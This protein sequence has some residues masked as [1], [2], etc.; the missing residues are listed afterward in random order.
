M[1]GGSEERLKVF[2]SLFQLEYLMVPLCL[3]PQA[4]GYSCVP[5]SK[6]EDGL[7]V[8]VL[9]KKEADV[10]AQQQ[11]LVESLHK[12]LGSNQTLSVNVEGVKAL[13][14]DQ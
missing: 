12:I 11:Q 10:R 1:A 3:F 4:V 5:V 8:L 13:P 2:L 6:D 9:N 14:N 7:V